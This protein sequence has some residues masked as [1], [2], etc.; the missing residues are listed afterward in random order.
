[1][2]PD[3]LADLDRDLDELC[4]DLVERERRQFI[5]RGLGKWS[6]PGIPHKGWNCVLTSDLGDDRMTCEMCE[7]ASIRYVHI[8]VHEQYEDA[9]QVGRV[10]G[11]HMEGDLAAAQLREQRCKRR[12]KERQRCQEPRVAAALSWVLAAEEILHRNGLRDRERQFVEDM[13]N[14]AEYRARRGSRTSFVPSYR[15]A[16]WFRAIYVRVALAGNDPARRIGHD[17]R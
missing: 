4:A 12:E 17:A 14:K 3:A 2:P 6:A 13:R 1:V 11:G 8:M 9:L 16:A 7:T 5:S 15:Q 10:C